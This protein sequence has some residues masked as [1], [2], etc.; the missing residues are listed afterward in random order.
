MLDA[1][2]HEDELAEFEGLRVKDLLEDAHMS[3]EELALVL[4]VSPSAVYRWKSGGKTNKPQRT[5]RRI[6][7]IINHIVHDRIQMGS[8]R[9][10]AFRALDRRTA[11]LDREVEGNGQVR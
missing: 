10:E 1:H 6:M 11:Y 7:W 3:A 4:G 9:Q 5:H 8:L 2:E